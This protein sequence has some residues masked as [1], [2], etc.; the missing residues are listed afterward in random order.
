MGIEPLSH[1]VKRSKQLLLLSFPRSF[2]TKL[3]LSVR[4]P[5]AATHA[6]NNFL[7]LA[8]RLRMTKVTTHTHTQTGK[9]AEETGEVEVVSS[10]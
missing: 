9:K 6:R 2:R 5:A 4:F 8:V 7:T 3:F 10:E 1:F